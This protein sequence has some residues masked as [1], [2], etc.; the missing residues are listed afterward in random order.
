M[1][2][3]KL[4]ILRNE[5]ADDH[6]LWE[7]A[8]D[9]YKNIIEWKV[10]DI[11]RSNWL[12]EILNGSFDGLLAA[13]PG[14]T[15]PFKVLYDERV[16][17][18]NI[19]CGIPVYPSLEEIYIYEDKKYFSYWLKANKIPHPATWV[20]YYKEEAL[21]FTQKALY[22][23][24]AKTNLGASGS[25]VCFLH[26]IKDAEKYILNTFS[27]RGITRNVGPKWKRKGFAGRVFRKLL[28]PAQFRLKMSEYTRSNSEH[29]KDF[30]ILQ[31]YI[32]HDYEWR[33]VRIG[34]SFFAHKKLKI[35]DKASGS[36]LKGY[37]DPPHDLLDFVKKITDM[38]NFVSQAVDIFVSEKGEYLVNEMQCIF[39]QS[40]PHQMIINGQ[41]GRYLFQNDQWI[42]EPGDF[43]RIESFQLRLENFIEI[44][45]KKSSL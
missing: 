4:A 39:G 32:P 33:C 22:P 17:I 25:G 14:W 44:L 31:Q 36:L 1:R 26:S 30:V 21:E 27:G 35:K 16:T 3:L 5:V 9:F 34:D 8:C 10:I 7:K 38:R 40:D 6:I 28:Q 24:V 29:Q 41:P 23:M 2:K 13:P 19:N 18:L 37:E 15:T 43:N 11:T 42:F 45:K 20:Y 12:E